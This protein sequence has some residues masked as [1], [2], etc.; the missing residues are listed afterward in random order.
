MPDGEGGY[1]KSL[2][3]KNVAGAISNS[4]RELL[5]KDVMKSEKAEAK[6]KKRAGGVK[7]MLTTPTP[8]LARHK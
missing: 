3:S 5:R 6:D 7:I 4:H 8:V 1:R 2:T